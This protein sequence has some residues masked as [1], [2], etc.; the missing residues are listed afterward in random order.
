MEETFTQRI[1]RLKSLANLRAG[2]RVIVPI[3]GRTGTLVK[4]CAP[5]HDGWIVRWDEP[6]FGVEQGRVATVNLEREA[7]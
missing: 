7:V 6:V 2:E 5:A 3:S 4:R 1:A